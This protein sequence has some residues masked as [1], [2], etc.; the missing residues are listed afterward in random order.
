M[1]IPLDC[2]ASLMPLPRTPLAAE[3]QCPVCGRRVT[4]RGPPPEGFK[5]P[6]AGSKDTRISPHWSKIWPEGEP[7]N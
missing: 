3:V 2:P 7:G 6:W 4:V 5:D 1:P